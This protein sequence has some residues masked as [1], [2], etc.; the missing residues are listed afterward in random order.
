MKQPSR[1]LAAAEEFLRRVNQDRSLPKRLEVEGDGPV[2]RLELGLGVYE[3]GD[4]TAV[5]QELKECPGL[6]IPELVDQPRKSRKRLQDLRIA[7]LQA[8]NRKYKSR[9]SE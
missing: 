4:V 9:Y 7:R 6:I 3:V 2:V 8:L 5:P 1:L